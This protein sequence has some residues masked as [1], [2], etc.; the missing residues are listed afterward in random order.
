MLRIKGKEVKSIYLPMV[1]TSLHV[2]ASSSASV[3]C[4]WSKIKIPDVRVNEMV[5]DHMKITV[6][7]DSHD[8]VHEVPGCTWSIISG[9]V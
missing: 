9:T 2:L 5:K 4:R 3:C 1:V 7:I 8:V 6:K